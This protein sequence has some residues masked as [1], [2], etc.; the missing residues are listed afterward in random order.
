[1]LSWPEVAVVMP[2]LNEQSHLQSAVA[3]ILA[4]DYPIDFKV[5]LAI[6][7]SSDRTQE[8]ADQI[9]RDNPRVAIVA[10]PTGR[11]PD[12]LNAAIAATTEP[13]IV[14][15]DAHSELS[16]GY[17]KCAVE[18][19]LET[20][21]DNVGGI[22]G[23]QGST[24]FQRAVATA[25]TS[26]L[27]V[28]SSSFH[29][30]G[31]PGPAETVYLGVF[32]RSALE[33]VGGYDPAFTRAQDWEMNFRIRSTGGLIWFNPNLY[34]TY[35]PRSSLRA[36]AKQYFDYGSWRHELMRTHPET[37]KGSSALRY[38]APP[39]ALLG[40]LLGSTMFTLG[41]VRDSALFMSAGLAPLGYLGLTLIS[42]ISL[43]KRAKSG[44]F[45]LPVVLATMQMSWGAGFLLSRSKKIKT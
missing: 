27:G 20:R 45:W 2:V 14:R 23:A 39:V 12:A 5:V 4:Q 21:A 34:V 16:P 31:N 26:P 28:G 36:L 37:T 33:R 42:S 13:I 44:T 18:T 7:P 40:V 1:M 15:V 6:G 8:V 9:V 25:M 24:P 32:Q 11:T 19:L 17:I 35:H 22:M 43:V 38:F 10:N 41:I 3:S 29:V 30:G